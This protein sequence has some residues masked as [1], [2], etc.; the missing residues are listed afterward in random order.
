[1]FGMSMGPIYLGSASRYVRGIL[2]SG[3]SDPRK[4]EN[5]ERKRRTGF[6]FHHVYSEASCSVDGH[7][8]RA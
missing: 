2:V 6:S 7:A 8:L 5:V 3:P 4:A 1:M